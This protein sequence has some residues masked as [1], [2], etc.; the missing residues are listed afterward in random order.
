MVLQTYL[1][2]PSCRRPLYEYEF[3]LEGEVRAPDANELFRCED[4][5]WQGCCRELSDAQPVAEAQ[6][7]FQI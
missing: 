3:Q 7:D 6:L 4:C 5:G 2:C 1:Y